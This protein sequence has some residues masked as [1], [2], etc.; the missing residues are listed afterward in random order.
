M[1]VVRIVPRKTIAMKLMLGKY[2]SDAGYW[3]KIARVLYVLNLKNKS[4]IL[5]DASVCPETY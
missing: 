5:S 2:K 3:E 4:I 1:N